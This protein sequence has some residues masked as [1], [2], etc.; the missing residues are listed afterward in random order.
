MLTS[1]IRL[2]L[3]IPRNWMTVAKVKQYGGDKSADGKA[4][5]DQVQFMLPGA[6]TID[7]VSRILSTSGSPSR[8]SYV[9]L[10]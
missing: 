1:S 5:D 7:P 2:D 6:G 4:S 10:L 8:A 9:S 3:P